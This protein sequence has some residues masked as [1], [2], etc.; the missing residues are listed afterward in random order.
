MSADAKV[1]Q[2]LR[3]LAQQ[4]KPLIDAIPDLEEVMSFEGRA[5]SAQAKIDEL[6]GIAEQQKAKN[7]QLDQVIRQKQT[8][9]D[10]LISDGEE[11]A[12]LII[13]SATQKA[14]GIA[15]AAK[16]SAEKILTDA[17]ASIASTQAEIDQK[18]QQLSELNAQLIEA[19]DS[20]S[21]IHSELD[22]I[23]PR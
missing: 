10:G 3:M 23:R 2:T 19:K 9:R 5:K 20:L 14:A 13:S 4:Y 1:L 16:Q 18:T 12:S 11:K 17:K 21:K 22:R 7:A 6:N 8:E 15:G